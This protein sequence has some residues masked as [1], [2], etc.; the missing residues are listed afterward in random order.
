LNET[1][2]R[3]DESG[4]KLGEDPEKQRQKEE[5]LQGVLNQGAQGRNIFVDWCLLPA[6]HASS[7]AEEETT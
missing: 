5:E 2:Q 4:K 3:S 6:P 1:L 7:V